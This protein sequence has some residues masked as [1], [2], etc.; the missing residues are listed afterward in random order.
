M[1]R[2]EMIERLLTVLSPV[3]PRTLEE[4]LTR[5]GLSTGRKV[6]GVGAVALREL[7]AR[8]LARS[9]G[10][11]QPLRW[12]AVA[13]AVAHEG[14]GSERHPLPQLD[15]VVAFTTTIRTTAGGTRRTDLVAVV[16]LGPSWPAATTPPPRWSTALSDAQVASGGLVG[17]RLNALARA[18]AQLRALRTH[19]ALPTLPTETT[20]TDPS[21]PLLTSSKDRA[22]FLAY[23]ASVDR[24]A[25]QDSAC[26]W[27]AKRG[28]ARTTD[29][30]RRWLDQLVLE[31]LVEEHERTAAD[32][33]LV[34]RY[35]PAIPT[36]PA[37][38][39]KSSASAVEPVPAPAPSVSPLASE[40]EPTPTAPS[41]DAA[42]PAPAC[43]RCLDLE[44]RIERGEETR[45]A[46]ERGV[47]EAYEREVRRL[48][49]ESDRRDIAHDDLRLRFCSALS[50]SA[51]VEWPAILDRVRDVRDERDRFAESLSTTRTE[52]D[53]LA[54]RRDQVE[55]H[56]CELAQMVGLDGG[57]AWADVLT[58][59]AYEIERLTDKANE[60]RPPH[61]GEQFAT[62]I[63][64]WLVSLSEEAWQQ[65]QQARTDLA[66]ARDLREQSHQLEQ[67]ALDALDRLVGA[68]AAP[69][70]APVAPPAPELVP[71]PIPLGPAPAAPP[72]LAK[73]SSEDG[74]VHPLQ[75][76]VLAL[77][78][79]GHTKARPIAEQLKE[80]QHRVSSALSALSLAGWI[81]RTAPGHYAPGRRA[82]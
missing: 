70:A 73:G 46:F 35:L 44:Y 10:S 37:P 5:L 30:A 62:S 63:A 76:A 8:G 42:P 27:L 77:V 17:A 81:V 12:L 18:E 51:Q 64:G 19:T 60:A 16:E 56:R 74:P 33:S 40:P 45:E 21:N 67:S 22:E 20:M 55:G 69:Q 4:L 78:L 3:E 6:A 23:L 28:L 53:D 29:E 82:A 48:S 43:A 50:L 36:T 57:A 72:P 26:A 41:N 11:S 52:R 61:Q 66:K 31:G 25:R 1:E 65:V 58:G 2:P 59:V 80:D 39:P 71:D 15:A 68:P 14:D 75:R 38:L 24:G 32:G 54:L 34:V 13:A 47:R 7:R 79:E 49:L 9:H